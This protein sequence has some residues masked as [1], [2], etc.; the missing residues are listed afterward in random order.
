M[1]NLHQQAWDGGYSIAELWGFTAPVTR[2][3]VD[4]QGEHL[5]MWGILGIVEYQVDRGAGHGYLR[6]RL[7]LGQWIAFGYAGP[8]STGQPAPQR[9][10]VFEDAKFGRK[11]SAI[12][13][14]TRVFVD[15]RIV[16]AEFFAELAASAI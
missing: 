14:A 4:V 12:G 9:L 11:R 5:L 8:E 3:T 13:D 2:A 16:H 1:A 7:A 6:Q 10:P 15:A